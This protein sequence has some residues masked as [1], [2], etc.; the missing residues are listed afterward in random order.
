MAVKPYMGVIRN[1]V[2]T[3]WSSK[4]ENLSEPDSILELEYVY[5]Y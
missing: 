4:N 5:G 3:N 2:P 1:S